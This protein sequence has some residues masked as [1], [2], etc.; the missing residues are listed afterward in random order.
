MA[1][2]APTIMP[3]GVVHTAT[4]PAYRIKPQV[5]SKVAL[6][7]ADIWPFTHL[8]RSINT[9]VIHGYEIIWQDDQYVPEWSEIDHSGGYSSG[10]TQ[11]V[12]AN[13][14]FVKYDLL[15]V[16]RTGEHMR[17][18]S[19]EA[20]GVT[21][22][23]TRGVGST[24]VALVDNDP[25]FKI[26][27]SFP[28]GSTAGDPIVAQMEQR[29]NY[30]V[31]CRKSVE[32]TGTMSQVEK[33]TGDDLARQRMKKLKL[34]KIDMEKMAIFGKKSRVTTGTRPVSTCDGILNIPNINTYN[35]G[36]APMN[37]SALRAVMKTAFRYASKKKL[38]A[39]C[40]ATAIDRIDSWGAG[41]LELRPAEETYGTTIN[42]YLTSF[43]ELNLINHYLLTGSVYGGYMILVDLSQC[44]Y[45]PLGNRD[46]QLRSN[47]KTDDGYDGQ[48]DEWLA[49]FTFKFEMGAAH[50]LV[51][52]IT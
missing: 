8:M 48:K 45:C 34:M 11:I 47:I 19:V 3:G 23:V 10:A 30:T 20:D 2:S 17:V 5:S 4:A 13:D 43:G 42:R 16:P 52:N 36:G 14:Y 15:V 22:N 46:L 37:E 7:D 26:G 12:V 50:S 27:E 49:E 44:S 28:E 6:Y 9:E 18:T 25:I 29:S 21:L 1:L 51:Y 39:L 32:Q 35:L 41:K 24:A 33:W 38:L 40:G 31:I